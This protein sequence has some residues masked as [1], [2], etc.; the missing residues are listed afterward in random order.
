[1]YFVP[2]QSDLKTIRII[3]GDALPLN[4]RLT[5]QDVFNIKTKINRLVPLMRGCKDYETFRELMNTP[6]S[7]TNALHADNSIVT[8]DEATVI[9]SSVWREV[10]NNNY[11]DSRNCLNSFTEYMETMKLR[12]KDFEHEIL[13]DTNG[14]ITGCIW[15]TS[16]MRNNF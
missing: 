5:S 11:E 14:E 10:M 12:D 13:T 6:R 16:T 9:H 3:A 15:M 1:M 7:G 4:K 2:N 8:P